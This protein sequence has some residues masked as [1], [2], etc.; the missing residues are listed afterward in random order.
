MAGTTL[1]TN[2]IL[3]VLLD[4]PAH[5]AASARAI[6]RAAREGALTIGPAT[7]AELVTVFA[8]KF[9][10]ATAAA[11]TEAFLREAGVQS[12]PVHE[13]AA[14]TAG[15]A[16]AAH[17]KKRDPSAVECPA[18]GKRAK[19]ECPHCG[20]SVAWRA[21]ILTDFLIGA[22]AKHDSGRI[23]TRDP[24]L[25]GKIEGLRVIVPGS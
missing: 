24:H 15:L 12:T 10:A 2:V 18:C 5:A 17:L 19:H 8:R 7:H 20:R 4:D 14:T 16:Y 9:G 6:D 21:H 11:R 22:H 1:D 3:D 25:H 13:L 23:L